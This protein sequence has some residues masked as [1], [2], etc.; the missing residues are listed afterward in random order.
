MNPPGVADG[1]VDPIMGFSHA[2]CYDAISNNP[3]NPTTVRTNLT[4]NSLP[5]GQ[6]IPAVNALFAIYGF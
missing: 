4:T 1:V 2:D 5:P 6:T 3:S